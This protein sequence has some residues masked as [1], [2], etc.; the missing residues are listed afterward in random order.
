MFPDRPKE[1]QSSSKLLAD[2]VRDHIL[3]PSVTPQFLKGDK[4]AILKDSEDC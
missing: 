3:F 4:V 1:A 2:R